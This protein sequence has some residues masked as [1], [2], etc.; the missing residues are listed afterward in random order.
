[1]ST[2]GSIKRDASGRWFFVVDMAA[3][4]GRR[5]QV[6]R[7]GFATKKEAQAELDALK[8]EVSSG[9]YVEVS[10]ITVRQYLVETWLPAMSARVRPS[11]H[12]TYTRLVNKHLVPELGDIRLQALDASA[13][14][15]FVGRLSESGLSA[16]SVRNIHAVLGKAMADAV[17]LGSVRVNPAVKAKL[18]RLERVKPR[19][20]STAQLGQF[21]R[22]VDGDRLAPLWRFLVATGCRRG[23]ALGVRWSDVDLDAKLVRIAQQRVVVGGTVRVGAPKTNAGVRSLAIDGATVAALRSWKA[24]QSAE[25]LLMGAGWADTDGLVFTHPDG[26]GLWPQTITARFRTIA[27]ELGYPAIGLHGLRHSAATFMIASGVSPKLVAERLGHSHIAIT[28]A[29][30]SHVLPAHDQAAADSFGSALDAAM[31]SPRSAVT[32]L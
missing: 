12:D 28:L 27:G 8:G 22:H 30:Y 23:E 6:R 7:R 11:T 9:G 31:D 5:R 21:L 32:N 25:R 29:L 16:K 4:D 13:V 1:M 3:H 2:A 14:T 15:T 26:S 17:D 10:K 20:W 19:A 24:E 18:P